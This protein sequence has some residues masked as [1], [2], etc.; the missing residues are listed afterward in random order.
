MA[1][2]VFNY[3]PNGT[4]IKETANNT[5]WNLLGLSGA[6]YATYAALVAAHDAI[7]PSQHDLLNQH[8]PWSVE[9]GV[10]FQT[11]TIIDDGGSDTTGGAY[12]VVFN[13]GLTAPTA[14]VSGILVMAG[15]PIAVAKKVYNIWYKKSTADDSLTF[16][17]AF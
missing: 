10:F 3:A 2:M 13:F 9:P 6:G 12:Y 11:I 5:N 1:E 17:P 7:Y 8:Y 15:Q 4:A 14:A 16:I